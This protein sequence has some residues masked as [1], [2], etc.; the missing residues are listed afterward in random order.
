VKDLAQLAYS[1][2]GHITPRLRLRF[3][4]DYFAGETR[5]MKR[6]WLGA[7]QA[8]V[9]AMGRRAKKFNAR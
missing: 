1:V 4:R 8:K 5:A 9:E 6:R 2:P 7:V 3:C